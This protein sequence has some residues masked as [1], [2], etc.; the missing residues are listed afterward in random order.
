MTDTQLSRVEWIPY[1]IN[2]EGLS[3]AYQR[4]QAQVVE[5][6]NAMELSCGEKAILIRLREAPS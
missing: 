1:W 5:G 2:T 3:A 6:I 4:M